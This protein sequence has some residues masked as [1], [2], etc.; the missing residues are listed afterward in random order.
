MPATPDLSHALE[1]ALQRYAGL[2]RAIA[3]R[4]RLHPGEV[5]ELLQAIRLRLW[6]AMERERI[7]EVT[8]SYMYRTA[9][10]ASID[11]I[12][13]RR[14]HRT[15]R[16][17]PLLELER[18]EAPGRADAAVESEE[19]TGG[20]LRLLDEL[21]ADRRTALKLHL[22]G[23]SAGEIAAMF[24][25]SAGRTRNLLHRALETLRRRLTERGLAPPGSGV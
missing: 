5:D 2:V 24:D 1:A 12:R 23:Y 25:W 3:R 17:N 13:A 10:S 18:A 9:M 21:P 15:A 7:T 20:I 19:Q 11:L 8:S 16:G 22:A 14:E 4:H 6:R